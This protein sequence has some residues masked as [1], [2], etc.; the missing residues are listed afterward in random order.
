M[1]PR[2]EDAAALRREELRY[3]YAI[4]R[5]HDPAPPWPEH[6]RGV[7][8]GPV[9]T[10][11]HAGLSA[12][13]GPVP[14]AEFGEA[15]LRARLEDLRWLE[16]VA[17]AHQRVVDTAARTA[18]CVVPLRLATVCRD[19]PGV[20]R[21]MASGR[22]RFTAALDRLDGKVEWGVKVYA[23]PGADT[24]AEQMTAGPSTG[25]REPVEQRAAPAH[26]TSRGTG[27]GRPAAE[28]RSGR[29]YLR[30]RSA[31]RR[32]RD[33]WWRASRDDARRVHETLT[34]LAA[35]TSL[36]S[37][38]DAELSGVADPQVL[39]AAF[40]VDGPDSAAFATR[41]GELDAG[42]PAVRVELTGPWAPYSFLS[43]GPAD[44]PPPQARPASGGGAATR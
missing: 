40:L 41:V 25:R 15:P 18:R 7:A 5:D 17:R 22:D 35:A 27:R 1:D 23:A 38:Q 24:S 30:R 34:P 13:T 10:V 21:L 29:N 12:L 31:E 6:L 14:A 37:P 8:G 20:R 3:V 9:H 28:E 36:H 19:E 11:R 32:A 4:T 42:L 2:P 16:E 33:E 44:Q 39:N 43:T 26:G